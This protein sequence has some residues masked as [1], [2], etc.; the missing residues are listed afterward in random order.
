MLFLPARDQSIIKVT[1]GCMD[2]IEALDRLKG[3][4]VGIAITAKPPPIME[5]FT[6]LDVSHDYIVLKT[7]QNKRRYVPIS[8]IGWVEEK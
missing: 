2:M 8:Q 7:H 4:E 3:K 1:G 5:T 6:L